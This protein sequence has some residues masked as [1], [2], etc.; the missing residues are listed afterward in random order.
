[1]KNRNEIKSTEG[2]TKQAG[3]M[4]SKKETEIGT[5]EQKQTLKNAIEIK[6]LLFCLRV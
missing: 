6:L 5:N 4:Q 1:M 3:Q 2:T